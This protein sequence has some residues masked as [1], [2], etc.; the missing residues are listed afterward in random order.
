MSEKIDNWMEMQDLIVVNEEDAII[1][2]IL[3]LLAAVASLV[4]IFG[5]LPEACLVIAATVFHF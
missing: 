4:P 5:R 2:I 3:N 1:S